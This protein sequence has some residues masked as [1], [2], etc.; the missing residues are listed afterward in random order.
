MAMKLRR[1]IAY[2]AWPLAVFVAAGCS[3]PDTVKVSGTVTWEGAP[4]PQGDIVFVALDP[5]VPAAAGKIVDGAYSFRCKPGEKHVV[6]QSYRLSG[7]KTPEGKAIGE[8]YVPKRYSS[9]STLAADVTFD[10]ENKFDF[11]LKP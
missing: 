3:R 11:P 9:E 2:V 10:G 5:H 7:K 4:M 8:M 1:C 6:I